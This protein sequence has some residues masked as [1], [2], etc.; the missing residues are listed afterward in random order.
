MARSRTRPKPAEVGVV[1][2]TVV[3]GPREDGR[4]YWRGRRKAERDTIWT[5]WATREEA[6]AEVAK[7]VA[8]GLSDSHPSVALAIPRTVEELLLAWLEERKGQVW[9]GP[10]RER[11]RVK[12]MI[13]PI[14]YQKYVYSAR[15]VITWFGDV[16]L[17]NV[18]ARLLSAYVVN[19]R[20]LDTRV[21]KS[22]RT[23]AAELGVLEW[24]WNWAL[25]HRW[26]SG[27]LPRV[28]QLDP[29]EYVNNRYTPTVDEVFAILPWLTGDSRL[30]VQLLTWAGAR[31]EEITGKLDLCDVD[32]DAGRITLHGKR[33][34]VR[35][36]PIPAELRQTIEERVR[37]GQPGDPLLVEEHGCLGLRT[38]SSVR[39]RGSTLRGRIARACVLAGVP[40][41]TPHGLRRMADDL[42]Y[43]AGVDP[44]ITAK[45]L[46]QSPEVALRSYRRVR[47]AKQHSAMLHAGLDSVLRDHGAGEGEPLDARDERQVDLRGASS[48]QL[49]AE[50]R[51]RRGGPM[52]LDDCAN[53]GGYAA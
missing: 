2:L 3:R 13:A 5:G 28:L 20:T 21:A 37:A 1:R 49:E 43:E 31:L 19:R 52:L 30:A 36:I 12:G 32:L 9:Q 7:L 45:I 38:S 27:K 26:V 34:K 14:S 53:T 48:E 23:V 25:E 47:P 29:D 10:W 8:S 17:N 50:L 40:V 18:S 6:M 16:T 11:P 44:G 46:G 4:Y 41:F 35:T 42:L 39:V 24:S 15:H 51:R 22:D 33:R